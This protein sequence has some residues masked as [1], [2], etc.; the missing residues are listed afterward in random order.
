MKTIRVLL[1][2]IFTGLFLGVACEP[3]EKI[4]DIPEVN[5]KSLNGPFLVQQGDITLR[6]AELVFG[7]K[8]GNS[9]FGVDVTQSPPDTINLYLI[10]FEKVNGVY[11]SIDADLYGRK[12]TIRKDPKLER[13][14]GA[15][16]GEI[17]VLITYVLKPPFDTMRYEF[18]ILDR[19]GNMSNIESTS[20][21][22]Y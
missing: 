2:V 6:G 11:D 12:Y 1:P 22:S 17:K 15:V 5:F 20:D 7:F 14:D 21:F 3:E 16:K 13:S 4:S 8:D 19:A 18:Y 10:P 9:D